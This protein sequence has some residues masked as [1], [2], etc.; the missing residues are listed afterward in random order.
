MCERP[1]RLAIG[2]QLD[3]HRLVAR[4]DVS[5]NGQV[6]LIEHDE[7]WAVASFVPESQRQESPTSR[8]AV[9]AASDLASPRDSEIP[10]VFRVKS[11]G[12]CSVRAL[13]SREAAG[14]SVI[15]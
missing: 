3:D 12:Y 15:D 11:S 13:R 14:L 9:S 2:A 6:H 4:R 8:F 10:G 7:G 1:A 5:W